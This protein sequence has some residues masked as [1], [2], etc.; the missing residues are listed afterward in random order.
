MFLKIYNATEVHKKKREKYGCRKT[1]HH[2]V[3]IVVT[4]ANVIMVK[5]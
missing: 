2:D 3:V 5:G 1:E 4:N